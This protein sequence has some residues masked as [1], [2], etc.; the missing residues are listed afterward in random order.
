MRAQAQDMQELSRGLGRQT[1]DTLSKSLI[2]EHFTMDTQ[3]TIT[4]SVD[5]PGQ[6]NECEQTNIMPH[7][8]DQQGSPVDRATGETVTMTHNN[9]LKGESN[10]MERRHSYDNVTDENL[11]KEGHFMASPSTNTSRP[12]K[13][14]TDCGDPI[15]RTRSSSKTRIKNSSK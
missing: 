5:A 6:G 10:K 1:P 15:L 8:I 14:K 7:N 9:E 4:R 3:E 12:K 11:P 13:L 2:P